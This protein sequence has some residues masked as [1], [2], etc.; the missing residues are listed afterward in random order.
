MW[1]G[2]LCTNPTSLKRDRGT[3][4]LN[5][6]KK[7]KRKKSSILTFVAVM[8][9][10]VAKRGGKKTNTALSLR[11]KACAKTAVPASPLSQFDLKGGPA[12][13]IADGENR[14]FALG[15]GKEKIGKTVD[16]AERCKGL[17]S[18]AG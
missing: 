10:N 15:R 7:R 16:L 14:G 17:R 9:G 2:G 5:T 18:F 6:D 1:K 13:G 3:F 12:E 11:G 4:K 8:D